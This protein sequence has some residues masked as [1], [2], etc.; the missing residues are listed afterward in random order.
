MVEERT[1]ESILVADCGTVTT[2][3]LLMDR[4][5]DGYRFIAQAEV[6]T[7]IDP[8]WEDISVGVVNAVQQLENIT[9]RTIYDR[10]QIV[11]P[12]YGMVGV[13]AFVNILSAPEPLHVVLAGLVREVSLESAKRAAMATYSD[14]QAILS[15]EGS[16]RS[17]QETWSRTIRNLTPDVVLLVGGVDGG[18]RRPVMELAEAVAL[19]ASM[20]DKESRPIVLYAGNT[21]LRPLVTQLLGDITKV[22]IADNVH[23]DAGTEH[24]GPVQ[25]TLEKYYMDERLDTV[26][27]VDNLLSWSR[28]PLLSTATAFA[29]VI[30]YL[31]HREGSNDRG[32]LGVD[33]GA[34]HTTFSANFDGQVYT[35]ISHHGST[36]KLVDWVDQ[37]GIELL[38]R[39]I[40]EEMSEEEVWTILYNHELHPHTIPQD[41][42]EF[43]VELAVVRELLRYTLDLAYP[44]WFTAQKSAGNGL[45]MPRIDPILV[46][47]G[48]VVHIPRPGQ[49]LLAIL[50]G[51]Q[52]TGI[53]SILMDVNRSAPAIG[54]IAGVKPLAAASAL[55]AGTISSLGTTISP[56]G[57]AKMGE[58]V[59]NM[60]IAYEHGGEL[61]V[62]VHH[63]EI[64]IS[65]L[66]PGQKATI[67][68]R[69]HRRIDIG[70]GFGK[71]GKV[72]VRGGLVG[73]IAD[74]R[75]RPLVLPRQAD[76]R[77][78]LLNG[79]LWDVGG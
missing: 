65:P 74:A 40:P 10:G 35:T 56:V 27:G 48:G 63:G 41:Q 76:A 68:L 36:R 12:R 38:M 67:T 1:I 4:V 13:D 3:L 19:A 39:W 45:L 30:D 33:V 78:R 51:L 54:A 75:G 71:A 50:D 21:S 64:E 79:W 77:R 43:W 11:T 34:A 9:G 15:R 31:W 59:L 72:K 32:V 47:G 49:A 17:P 37:H 23:P 44:T 73:L 25:E 61:D 53:A 42:K 7:T 28:V 5:E 16:L 29:R 70:F 62:E 66:L 26:P 18:A 22:D 24:L 8:P 46:S 14:I 55:N 58:T 2:K 60:H 52:P 6:A 20:L 69:P 57:K